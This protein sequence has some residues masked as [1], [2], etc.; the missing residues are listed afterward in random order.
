MVVSP[1]SFYKTKAYP[2]L[3][4]LEIDFAHAVGA[5]EHLDR[6]HRHADEFRAELR[7]LLDAEVRLRRRLDAA[8]LRGLRHRVR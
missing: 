2:Q 3:E 5:I 4:V 1:F 8:R 7:L 6:Q